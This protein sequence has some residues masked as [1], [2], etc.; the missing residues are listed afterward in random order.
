MFPKPELFR[1]SD[2]KKQPS[3]SADNGN[4]AKTTLGVNYP[5]PRC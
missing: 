4:I 1:D 3:Y 5:S 2:R